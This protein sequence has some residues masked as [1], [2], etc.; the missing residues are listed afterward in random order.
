M[1]LPFLPYQIAEDSFIGLVGDI[2]DEQCL[3]DHGRW[4][5][6]AAWALPFFFRVS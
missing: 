5:A 3:P 6:N 4:A 1:V 2:S